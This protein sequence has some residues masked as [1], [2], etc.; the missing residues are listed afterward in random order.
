MSESVISH[1]AI[2]PFRRQ[3]EEAFSQLGGVGSAVRDDRAD[4][5]TLASRFAVAEQVWLELALRPLIP[6]VR[7]GIL[8]DDRWAS[9]DLETAIEETGDTMSEFIES[10]FDEVD[11]EW[12]DPPVEHYRDQGKFY[13][14]ATPLELE[15]LDQLADPQVQAKVTKIFQG[16]RAAFGPAIERLNADDD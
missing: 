10:G 1:A 14:F 11:L 8:T 12:T 3:M 16:Y 9:E 15:R 6:Q 5:S 4:G 2:D 7:V 13:Y